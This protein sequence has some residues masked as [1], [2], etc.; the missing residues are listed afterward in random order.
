MNSGYA[1]D[2]EESLMAQGIYFKLGQT[3]GSYGKEK[4]DDKKFLWMEINV[5]I[6]SQEK[7]QG[8]V[9]LRYSRASAAAY[10]CMS[11]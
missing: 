4:K 5:L 10:L 1:T 6:R 8:Q 2:D 11:V 9:W 7:Y 3:M